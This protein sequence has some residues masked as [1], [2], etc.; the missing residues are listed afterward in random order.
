VPAARLIGALVVLGAV[1]APGAPAQTTYP[2]C[3]PDAPPPT[4]RVN[5][6]TAPVYT[7]HDLLVRVRHADESFSVL[8]FDV[9]GVRRLAQDEEADQGT[10]PAIADAPG[11]LTATATLL[12]TDVRDDGSCTVSGSASFEVRAATTPSVSKLRRPRPFLQ[13][14]GLTWDSEFRFM[15]RPGSTGDRRP[16]TVE[17]RGSRRAKV[18]GPG[19]KAGTRTFAMRVSDVV[20]EVDEG[21]RLPRC[22]DSTLVCPRTIRTWP[23]GPQVDVRELGGRF[24]PAA[25]RV[26]VTL[27]RGYPPFPSSNRW[28]RS[29][30]GVDVKVLQGGQTIARLRI[31]GRCEPSGQFSRC[32][33]KK[34]TTAL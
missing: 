25:V 1:L 31:A 13:T 28:L 22:G 23:T 24:V 20:D 32:R 6:K 34:V 2:P 5:G 10:V 16:I 26:Q 29:P 11:T 19:V 21:G 7:T 18:P 4:F 8:S 9:S 17:A 15:V 30:A 33:F 14:P 12:I 3:A 27:P